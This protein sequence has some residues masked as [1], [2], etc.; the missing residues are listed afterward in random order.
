MIVVVLHNYIQVQVN[1]ILQKSFY[2]LR[3]TNLLRSLSYILEIESEN[4]GPGKVR[5]SNIKIH[6]HLRMSIVNVN[7]II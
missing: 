4:S 6:H 7:A 1:L 2:F 3:V 5:M